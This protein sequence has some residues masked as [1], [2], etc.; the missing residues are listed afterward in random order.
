M[1]LLARLP[2]YTAIGRMLLCIVKYC[3]H[4]A[5]FIYKVRVYT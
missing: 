2:A 4:S 5:Y 1:L 3:L